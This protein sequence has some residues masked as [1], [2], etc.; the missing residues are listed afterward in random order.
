MPTGKAFPTANRLL[1]PPPG[2]GGLQVQTEVVID[3]QSR[4]FAGQEGIPQ[5]GQAAV[6]LPAPQVGYGYRVEL[7]SVYTNST[8]QTLAD[9]YLGDPLPTNRVDHT[10]T[11][12]EDIAFEQ[13]PIFVPAGQI[14]TVL[15]TG[16]SPGAVCNARLQ[17]SIVQFVPVT[18]S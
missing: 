2:S 3:H 5:A 6:S 16:L 11:G 7:I 14:L 1:A 17:W 12:N 15:W 4:G 18:Y 9:I 13:P 10:D 8:N